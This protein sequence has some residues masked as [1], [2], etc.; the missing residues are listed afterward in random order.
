MGKSRGKTSLNWVITWKFKW[1]HKS[2]ADA[3]AGACGTA[4]GEFFFL[5]LLPA[6]TRNVC[7][8]NPHQRD[9]WREDMVLFTAV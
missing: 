3:A 1:L 7:V 6:Q 4:L 8:Q 2:I 5:M 9:P